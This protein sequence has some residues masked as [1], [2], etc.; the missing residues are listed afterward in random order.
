MTFHVVKNQTIQFVMMIDILYIQV[1]KCLNLSL[2]S[3]WV[4][5]PCIY[6][7]EELNI[8]PSEYRKSNYDFFLTYAIDLTVL[9]KSVCVLP[10]YLCIKENS[11]A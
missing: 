9:R 6:L 7:M 1:I 2:C 3:Y 5:F 10:Q 11:R 4:S 8:A